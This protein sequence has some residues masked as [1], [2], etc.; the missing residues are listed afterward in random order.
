MAHG[1]DP[2]D[3]DEEWKRPKDR[4]EPVGRSLIIRADH[5][6]AA[7]KLYQSIFGP[8]TELAKYAERLRAQRRKR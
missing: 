8:G 4:V 2:G 7:M 5:F 1:D 6:T 3:E